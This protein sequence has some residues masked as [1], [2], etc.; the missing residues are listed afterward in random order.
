[1]RSPERHNQRSKK[2]KQFLS[3][4]TCLLITLDSQLEEGGV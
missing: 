4:G 3:T 1:M 2:L